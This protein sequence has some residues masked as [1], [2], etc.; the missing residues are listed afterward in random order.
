MFAI[1]SSLHFV[2]RFTDLFNVAT[3]LLYIKIS[4][5]LVY[6]EKIQFLFSPNI[7][8]ATKWLRILSLPANDK[9]RNHLVAKP[10]LKIQRNKIIETHRVAIVNFPLII[11]VHSNSCYR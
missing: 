8:L 3:K 7:R 1:M 10:I 4:N 6:Q 11:V 5:M 9:T 2:S